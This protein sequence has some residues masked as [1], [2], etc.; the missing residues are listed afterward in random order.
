MYPLVSNPERLT[1]D[2]YLNGQAGG[3]IAP[4]LDTFFQGL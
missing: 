4:F 1:P 2:C 3:R